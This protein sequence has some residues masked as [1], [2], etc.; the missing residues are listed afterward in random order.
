MIEVITKQNRGSCM[1]SLKSFLELRHRVF[2]QRLG[3]SVQS[4]SPADGLELDEFDHDDTI[5]VVAR[6]TNG[7]V[8]AGLRLLE[9]TG[10]YLLGSHFRGFVDGPL[11]CDPKVFEISRFVADPCRGRQVGGSDVVKALIWGAQSYGLAA[12]LS[13][14]VSLS[15]IGLERMLSASECRIR[16]LGRPQ[17]IDGRKCVALQFDVGHYLQY[18]CPSTRVN[19]RHAPE[20]IFDTT[21]VGLAA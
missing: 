4:K 1:A 17:E 5:Y 20:Q 6:D 14:Y 3:W 9:T 2:V 10:P 11:P 15:Y 12:G 16:R 18:S 7:A 8:I 19:R 21:M 13:H